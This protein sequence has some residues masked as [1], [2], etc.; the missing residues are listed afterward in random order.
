MARRGLRRTRSKDHRSAIRESQIAGVYP[1]STRGLGFFS[2]VGGG[3]CHGGCLAAGVAGG[4]L[5]G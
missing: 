1:K 2:E 4:C 3:G 5:V